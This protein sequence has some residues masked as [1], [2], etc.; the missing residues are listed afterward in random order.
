MTS[1]MELRSHINFMWDLLQL[2]IYL[3]KSIREA[4]D[5]ISIVDIL[6]KAIEL[7]KLFVI[8]A[9]TAI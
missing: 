7:Y 2:L 8:K 4:I 5:R 9:I 6:A 1:H 3:D